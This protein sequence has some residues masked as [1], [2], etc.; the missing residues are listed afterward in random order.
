MSALGLV[1][2]FAIIGGLLFVVICFVDRRGED[3]ASARIDRELGHRF[4]GPHDLDVMHETAVLPEDHNAERERLTLQKCYVTER[5]G[6]GNVVD[7]T[8]MRIVTLCSWRER[9]SWSQRSHCSQSN[10][11]PLV[12]LKACGGA[13]TTSEYH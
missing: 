13:K 6:C 2:V 11:P 4:V 9:Y 5:V 7:A 8:W 12:T 10:V 1:R 3:G